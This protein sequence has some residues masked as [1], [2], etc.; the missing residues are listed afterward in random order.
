MGRVLLTRQIICH[1]KSKAGRT[2]RSERFSGPRLLPECCS[3]IPGSV[4]PGLRMTAQVPSIMSAS[5]LARREERR[6]SPLPFFR[7]EENTPQCSSCQLLL[8]RVWAPW[9]SGMGNAPAFFPVRTTMF[10]RDIA[11][12]LRRKGVIQRGMLF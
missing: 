11:S 9:G 5:S 2:M 4:L 6:Q 7:P 8:T 3:D 12:Q 1:R 10:T